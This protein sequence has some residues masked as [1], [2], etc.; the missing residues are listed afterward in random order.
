MLSHHFSHYFNADLAGEFRILRPVSKDDLQ[1]CLRR[2]DKKPEKWQ[3]P[4][5]GSNFMT[6]ANNFDLRDFIRTI[7]DYPKPGIQFRDVTTLIA[8]P[9]GLRASVDM[10]LRPFITADIDLSLIHI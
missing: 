9:V 10:L 8:D 4:V 1:F 6:A 3:S 5:S 7:P 2:G